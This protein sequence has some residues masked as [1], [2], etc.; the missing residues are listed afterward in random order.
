MQTLVS[1]DHKVFWNILHVIKLLPPPPQ[2]VIGQ[3][4]AYSHLWIFLV[5]LLFPNISSFLVFPAYRKSRKSLI[6]DV[7]SDMNHNYVSIPE[8][9]WDCEHEFQWTIKFSEIYCILL[10]PPTGSW[11]IFCIFSLM[12]T[13]RHSDIPK[14]Q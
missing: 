3:I 13:S 12:N 2:L 5:I 1:V 9:V 8:T 7:H 6:V 10:K 4:L 11:T 14:Y